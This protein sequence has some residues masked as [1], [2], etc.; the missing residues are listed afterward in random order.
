MK[1]GDKVLQRATHPDRVYHGVIID[2]GETKLIV[3]VR[4]FN[5]AATSWEAIRDLEL[6]NGNS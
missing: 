1:R 2:V 3:C 5:S 4:W 6:D